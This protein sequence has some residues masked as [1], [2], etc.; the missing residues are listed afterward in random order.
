MEDLTL[1]WLGTLLLALLPVGPSIAQKAEI[2]D[3]IVA[4]VNRQV[5]TRTEVLQEAL[6]LVVNRK[7]PRGLERKLTPAFLQQVMEMLINQ[8]ILLAEAN[9][10]GVDS[11]VETDPEQLV[12]RFQNRFN[13]RERYVRFLL[14]YGLTEKDIGDV[15]VR[16]KRVEK[17]EETKVSG[18]EVS[19][20][21]VREFYQKNRVRFGMSPY[22]RV[23]PAIRHR[24]LQNKRQ[25]H[26]QEWI[27]ELKKRSEV[28]VLVNLEAVVD[29]VR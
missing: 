5:I 27:A 16:H 17:I 7:G 13:K 9:R 8:R 10:Q 12:I 6:L 21:V 28:K 2:V 1:R 15:L 29:K 26:L 22:A 11:A 18:V 20:E 3:E 19:D 23:A 14:R 25:K 24:L 4:V